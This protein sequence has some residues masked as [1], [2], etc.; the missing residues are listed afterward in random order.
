MPAPLAAQQ[1]GKPAAA[2]AL[3]PLPDSAGWGIHVLTAVRDAGGALWLGTYG[4]G[5]LRLAPGSEAWQVIRHDT[6]ATSL[7][8]DYVHAVAFGPRGEIWYGTVGNGWGLS[9]DGGRTWRH[10]GADEL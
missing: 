7:S 5:L 1:D 4:H 2:P 6:A 10:W 8:W 3:P 9:T